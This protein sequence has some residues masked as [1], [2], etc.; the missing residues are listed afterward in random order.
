MLIFSWLNDRDIRWDK[1][2]NL[3][4]HKCSIKGKQNVVLWKCKTTLR[5]GHVPITVWLGRGEAPRKATN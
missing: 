4:L 1:G 2:L 3:I 5:L